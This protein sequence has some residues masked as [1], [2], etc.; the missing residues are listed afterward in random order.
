M[1][2][3]S[4]ASGSVTSNVGGVNCAAPNDCAQ[5]Y[6]HG[7]TV[8]L[9]ATPGANNTVSGWTGCDNP[10][11]NTCTMTMSA[12]K[13]VRAEFHNTT[14]PASSITPLLESTN[15]T[16]PGYHYLANP[17]S[18]LSLAAVELWLDGP[19]SGGFVKVTE[20]TGSATEGDFDPISLNEGDGTY[21]VKSR[22]RN[23]A[24]NHE[25]GSVE[26]FVLDTLDPTTTVTTASTQKVNSFG[27]E[28][29]GSDQ[30]TG[31]SDVELWVDGPG[32]GAARLAA[33]DQAS[34]NSGTFSFDVDE[35]AGA[36]SFHTIASDVTGNVEDAP[37][38]PDVVVNV[39]LCPGFESDPRV[40]VVGTPG[41][42][43]LEGTNAAEVFCGLAGNDTM[44]GRGGADLFVGDVGTDTVT[45]SERTAKQPVVVTVNNGANDGQKNEGDHVSTGI[46]IV[47][48]GKGNDIF[49]GD[50][51]ANTFKGGLGND[52][53]K[54]AG[55]KDKLYGE[56]G[57]DKLDGGPSKDTCKTGETLKAC[58]VR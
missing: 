21:M 4:V 12:A 57:K 2:G 45:Y 42:D 40:H 31:V 47:L 8:I 11:G 3:D 9:T 24:G 38:T 26:T 25:V 30:G 28:W 51:A 37:A 49:T 41:N 36:Y 27:L 34:G 13:T 22:A 39:V 19:G 18:G 14:M 1:N 16:T 44:R 43:K 56:K 5:N 52:T 46:E 23:D 7:T 29:T 10:S 15:D 48:G 35:G 17:G 55:A 33:T 6:P 20:E 53:L 50:G 54:G 58:E 32:A